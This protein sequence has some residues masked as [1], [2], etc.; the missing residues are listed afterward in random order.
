[1]C[2][3]YYYYVVFIITMFDQSSLMDTQEVSYYH[4]VATYIVTY[5]LLIVAIVII[6]TI[7]KYYMRIVICVCTVR[8]LGLCD[9]ENSYISIME[10]IITII[11]ITVMHK[12]HLGSYGSELCN[13]RI[14]CLI[15][16]PLPFTVIPVLVR[17]ITDGY[18]KWV[19]TCLRS[20]K[21]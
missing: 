5:V 21:C 19:G 6:L 18:Y 20:F 10:L 2:C 3:F 7:M 9:N 11:S 17:Y 13:A 1:M 4:I 15:L 14:S 16:S 12:V 8:V